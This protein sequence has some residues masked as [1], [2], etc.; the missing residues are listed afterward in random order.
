MNSKDYKKITFE[1]L[2]LIESTATFISDQLKK[3]NAADIE[4]KEKN[5]LVSFVDK[6]AEEK[7][8]S[9]LTQIIPEAGFITE[10]D[11]VEQSKKEWTWII[12]P[13]DGT[14]NY[15]QQI[16]YFAISVALM[17]GDELVVGIIYS[18]QHKECFYA[19]KD[20]GSYLNE[21]PIHVSSTKGLDNA[22][23][24]TGFPYSTD[25]YLPIIE[26]VG[27]FI[28][29]ARGVRRFG[30]AALD[31]AYVACGRVDAYY[32]GW[33]NSWDIAA[34][35]LIVREAGGRV[36]DFTGNQQCVDSGNIIASNQF[37]YSAVE[38]AVRER[39]S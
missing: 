36:K 10:E 5:S 38:S 17:E 25:N 37:I 32:E 11:T 9:G 19:W 6:S 33:I 23:I 22:I 13:L 8:V 7:L 15:L 30:A 29:H 27:F 18:V 31:L 28:E 24:A 20:G 1:C 21:V 2:P 12:D 14:T 26:T 39:F 3:V 4:V 34:G 16:P 35:I